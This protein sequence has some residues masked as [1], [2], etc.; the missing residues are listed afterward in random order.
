MEHDRQTFL[1]FWTIFLPLYPP[2][3]LK[4][5]TFEKMKKNNNKKQKKKQTNKKKHLDISFYTSVAKIM[6]ICCTVPEIGRV[7][8][9][10]FIVHFGLFFALL[11]H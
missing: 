10:T 2:K 6:M 1:S 5:P 7:M 11:P 8:D 3:N 4:N 9:V